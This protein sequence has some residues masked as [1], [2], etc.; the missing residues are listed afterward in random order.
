MMKE[1]CPRHEVRALEREFNDL[2]QDGAEHRAYTD[3]F[4]ELSLLCPTMVTPPEN[5][6]PD[7]MLDIMTGVNPTTLCQAIELSA[8]LTETQVKKGK[9]TRKGGKKKTSDSGKDKKKGKGKE[10]ESSRK[11]RKRKGAQNFVVTAQ[12]YQN[13]PA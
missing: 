8:T 7:S 12:T 3:C 9:L 1:F 11:F 13:P 5:G 2:K 6:L 10:A 4:E